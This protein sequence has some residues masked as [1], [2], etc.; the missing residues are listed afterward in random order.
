MPHPAHSRI[1]PARAG[2]GRRT[3]RGPATRSRARQHSGGRRDTLA[4]RS[5]G[6]RGPSTS[7]ARLGTARL[8]RARACLPWNSYCAGCHEQ[9]L[10]IALRCTCRGLPRAGLGTS[11]AWRAYHWPAL[12]GLPR[13]GLGPLLGALLRK[14]EDRL[15]LRLPVY[16]GECGVFGGVLGV[17]EQ[18]LPRVL[19]EVVLTGRADGLLEEVLR[20]A[21][22]RLHAGVREALLH[23]GDGPEV[24]PA[25]LD[26]VRPVLALLLGR[27]AGLVLPE[28]G[29]RVRRVDE[30]HLGD[31]GVGEVGPLG[32]P[33]Q[34]ADHAVL[35][36]AGVVEPVHSRVRPAHKHLVQ[37]RV[38]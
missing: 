17:L 6:R 35:A 34:A 21:P 16:G 28:H 5:I 25:R 19:V 32:L 13:V 20:E 3:G 7:P 1:L 18:L 23:R 9:G 29:Q 15:R 38:P 22:R 24:R 31:A 14:V 4:T 11:R 37:T 26:G 30:P 12:S 8:G 10:A 33:A 27:C 2:S 36:H